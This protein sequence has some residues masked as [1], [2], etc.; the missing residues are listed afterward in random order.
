MT[1]RLSTIHEFGIVV[2][3]NV[4][5]VMRRDLRQPDE[6]ESQIVPSE[7]ALLS[8]VP[9]W[10][11]LSLRCYGKGDYGVWYIVNVT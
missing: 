8:T 2:V 5:N 9:P 10:R 1:Y 3:I 4:S 7:R 11:T 6:D